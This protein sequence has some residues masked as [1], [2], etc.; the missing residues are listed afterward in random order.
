MNV[1]RLYAIVMNERDNVAVA[2][3]DI[4]R[5]DRV[6]FMV[7]KEIREIIAKSDIPFGHKLA[8]RNIPKGGEVIK[9]GEII[10]RAT[11]DIAVG[12]YVHVHNVESLRCRGD[13]AREI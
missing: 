3:R 8:I 2:L 1:E 10:G 7:G 13:L 12:E 11:A 6:V 5:G 4:K 9:Y